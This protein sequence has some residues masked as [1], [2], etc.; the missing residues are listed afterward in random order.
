MLLCSQV[1]LA[2]ADEGSW[3]RS[4]RKSRSSTAKASTSQVDQVDSQFR[5]GIVV[6]VSYCVILCNI[7]SCC[8]VDF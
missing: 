3:T 4:Q 7:V 1:T 8:G 5:Q 2:K 6:S